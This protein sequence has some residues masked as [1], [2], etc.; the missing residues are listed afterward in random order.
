MSNIFDPS[1]CD[2]CNPVEYGNFMKKV[3]VTFN[4]LKP[5]DHTQIDI[6]N[7]VD[8]ED[9][10]TGDIY[11]MLQE[12]SIPVGMFVMVRK[13]KPHKYIDFLYLK[14]ESEIK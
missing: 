13:G 5:G 4:T 6:P 11:S 7:D 8:V 10:V 9:T 3:C 14:N 12:K 2:D 1:V